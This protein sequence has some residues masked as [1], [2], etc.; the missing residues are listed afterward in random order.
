MAMRKFLTS[1]ADVFAYDA[2][3]KIVF[4]GKTLL[5]SSIEVSL[6]STPVRAG[7]GNQLQY[8][9]YHTGEMTFEI[10]DTQFNLGMLGATIGSDVKTSDNAYQEVN[11]EL[12]GT[13]GGAMAAGV[14]PLAWA[15]DSVIY[16]WATKQNGDSYRVAFT[17]GSPYTFLTL[18]EDG[19][20]VLGEIGDVVCVRYYAT[21]AS[22][23]SITVSANMIPNIV[24]LVLEAQLNSSDSTSNKIGIVQIIVP[25][26]TLS[27]G[28]SLSM[29]SDGVSN[30]P[31]SAT[32]LAY[33]D[34][35][36]TNACEREPFYAKIIELISSANW[37]DNVIALAV[38]GG[39]FTM[40]NST[41]ATLNVW[42]IPLSGPA[43]KA[44][45]A[46]L[47]FVLVGTPTATGTT[48]G[49]NTG[50]VTSLAVDGTAVINASISEKDDID[51]TVIVTVA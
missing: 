42:A 29:S 8:I 22:A 2:N 18:A 23:R 4:T 21:V 1:V 39:D 32:A 19:S 26:A 50:I 25:T 24:K 16:G 48:V 17:A 33:N 11:V 27:G 51:T 46:D 35:A 31:L 45:N 12:T 36:S 38:V 3:N 34:P 40:A 20:P 30:T 10:T 13:T 15:D 6:G 9:Y 41:T 14:T 5:D 44:P 49:L 28:F 47:D 37:W 7:R 43:F